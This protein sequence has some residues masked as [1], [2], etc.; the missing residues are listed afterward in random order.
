M[1]NY[2][3]NRT[4]LIEIFKEFENFF[5]KILNSDRT[6][7]FCLEEIK[8]NNDKRIVFQR[9]SREYQDLEA[10]RDLRN[11]I[12]HNKYKILIPDETIKEIRS[13]QNRLSKTAKDLFLWNVY[14]CSADMKLSEVLWVMKEK[15]FT[16][17]P[18]YD[19]WKFIGVLTETTITSWLESKLCDDILIEKDDLFIKSFVWWFWIESGYI[20]KRKD[21]PLFKIEN[22]FDDYLKRKERLWA[23]FLTNLWDENE[24][25]EWII[26]AWDLPKIGSSGF[27]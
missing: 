25:I 23:I 3:R 4:E 18:I 12:G 27:D 9:I 11:L 26:T 5:K 2:D 21:T 1:E 15:L 17:I 24:K 7:S 20:F 6:F 13:L 10:F 22:C 14:T 16:H 8:R 19:N